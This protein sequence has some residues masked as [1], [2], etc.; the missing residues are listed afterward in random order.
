[1]LGLVA[2]ASAEGPSVQ[3]KSPAL[4]PAQAQKKLNQKAHRFIQNA[5]QWN[6]NALFLARSSGLEMWVTREG[7]TYDFYRAE[8]RGKETGRSG[9]VVQMS[10]AGGTGGSAK[11]VSQLPS[12]T[13]YIDGVRQNSRSA[14]SFREVLQKGIYAGVDARSY[15]DRGLPRYDLIVAPG[16]NAKQIKLAFKGANA[17]NVKEGE[18]VLGTTLGN[19]K[20][21]KLFAY[22]IVGG[23]RKQVPASFKLVGK[24]VVGFE[25]GAYDASKQLIIDPLIYGTYYGGDNGVDEVRAVTADTKGGVYLTGYTQSA[26][27]PAVYGPY[28][29][30][31]FGG[32][33][34]F[35]TKLRGDAYV[36]EYAAYFGGSGN[37]FGMQI[38]VDPFGDVW[39]AGI[40]NSGNF[41]GGN[42]QYL[43]K[44]SNASPTSGTFTITYP[45]IGT[46]QPLAYNASPG[47][48]KTALQTLL[49]VTNIR[50]TNNSGTG[51]SLN[52]GG[53]YRII[54]PTQFPANLTVD[55]SNLSPAST[56]SVPTRQP[57]VF[58]MRW[59]QDPDTILSPFPQAILYF[60]GEQPMTLASF[61]IVPNANPGVTEPVRLSFG[62]VQSAGGTN[63]DIPDLQPARNSGYITRFEFDRASRSFFRVNS[64]TK[65]VTANGTATVDLSGLAVD[66]FGSIYI[67][68]TVR[69]AGNVD[70]AINPIFTT[71]QGVFENGRLLRNSDL[72]MRKYSANGSLIYSALLGGNRN[73]VAGGYDFDYTGNSVNTG[74]TLTIDEGLNAYITGISGSFNFPRTPNVYGE[75]F[76][77]FANVIVS[78]INADASQLLYSTNLRTSGSVLPAGIAVDARGNAFVTGN[79]HPNNVEFP[80]TEAGGDPTQ[81]GNPNE[82]SSFTIGSIQTT[83]D[84]L[85]PDND[86]VEPPLLP[87]AEG[88]IN[89]LNDTATNLLY[90]SYIGGPL[91]DRVYAPYVDRFGDVWYFGSVDTFRRYVRFASDGTPTVRQTT[92]SLPDALISPLAFK[93]F[94]D[95]AGTESV[96]T[97]YGVWTSLFPLYTAVNWT[98]APPIVA[99][100]LPFVTM[101]Y[102]RDGYIVKQR[103]G[104]AAINQITLTPDTAPGGLGVTIQGVVTLTDPAPVGGAEIDL[105]LSDANAASFVQGGTQPDLRVTIPG[106]GTQATFTIYTLPVPV[107]TNVQLQATYQGS[108]KI[109]QFVVVPWLQQLA[110]SP[111]SVV[112]GNQSSGRIT[113]AAPAPAG[114][115]NV[116][117]TTDTPSLISFPGGS[118]VNVPEGQTSTVFAIETQGVSTPTFPTI[119]ASLLGVGKTQTLTLTQANLQAIVLSPTRVAGGTTVTGRVVLDGKAGSSFDVNILID[120]GTDG[121]V[122]TPRTLT[123]EAGDTFK[124]FTI[125]TAFETANTTR[126]ITAVR[127]E[128]GT[129]SRQSVSTTLFID[130]VFLTGF[131]LSPSTID[132][133]DTATGVVTISAPAP[134]GGVVV[135][136]KSSNTTVATVPSTVIVPAGASTVQFDITGQT[137]AVDRTV[138]ISAIRG[139]T[140]FD[141]TLTVRGVTF[142]LS[143]DPPSVVGGKDNATGTIT[144]SNPAPAGGATIKLKSSQPGVAAVPFTVTVEEGSSTATFPITTTGVSSTREVTIT[145]TLGTNVVTTPLEVRAVGVASVNFSQNP[146][147][148][149]SSVTIFVTLEA[150]APAGGATVS[151]SASNPDVF[152]VFPATISIAAGETTGSVTVTTN[153][154]SRDLATTVTATYGGSSASNTLEVRR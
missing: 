53:V 22:Q 136:L 3:T 128:Q 63:S 109:T 139:T 124:T 58:V 70:T 84:A 122:I 75:V 72:F 147:T 135:N 56:Y 148:G 133:G 149:G 55:S 34:G 83:E 137:I 131:T 32:R 138:T 6:D 42:L 120:A 86:T 47:Q 2:V 104:L 98:H 79:V 9:Q 24:N 57:F 16:A 51:I 144:L 105:H 61:A 14:D 89:V 64:L 117:L 112:G 127:P 110:L 134:A 114:G 15:F 5:G 68:G 21:G 66:R 143:V 38:S 65:F 146:V 119:R 52:E 123:F 142:T 78:K 87:T 80:D 121:Y 145:A 92:A 12:I 46:T 94:P 19:Q 107:N 108:F 23:K 140:R 129:Y 31:P 76:G 45:G 28:G 44:T 116:D 48:V 150:P 13:R 25:L 132:G 103:I 39:I 4:T 82:P 67:G 154:V 18:I 60:G 40:T 36:H 49:G 27:F 91:D 43:K 106:G 141:R 153:R 1:M 102:V 62:G 111:T 10:F 95:N 54:L 93:R 152:R 17:V 126:K 113:L 30:Q 81:A 97:R 7:M 41:P 8:T 37:D 35:I 101:Q 26:I 29:F 96:S 50:V 90:G 125:K 69:F 20:H 59:V 99:S 73:D 115:V 11:G 100:P 118:V 71:T 88:F 130:A 77:D 33:D 151:L 85:D 74:T